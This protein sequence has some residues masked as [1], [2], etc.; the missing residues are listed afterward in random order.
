MILQ[1]MLALAN[2]QIIIQAPKL[3]SR[4]GKVNLRAVANSSLRVEVLKPLG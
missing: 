2:D 4:L 3:V 1:A